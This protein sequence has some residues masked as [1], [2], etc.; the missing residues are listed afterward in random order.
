MREGE[1]EYSRDEGDR[2]CGA[3]DLPAWPRRTLNSG[4]WRSGNG[5][6]RIPCRAQASSEW[7]MLCPLSPDGVGLSWGAAIAR[8]ADRSC[9]S[10]PRQR[11]G[12]NELPEIGLS[13]EPISRRP[14]CQCDAPC[15]QGSRTPTGD[16][17]LSKLDTS[18]W[19]GGAKSA[20][21]S[22]AEQ[23]LPGHRRLLF[24][25]CGARVG[26]AAIDKFCSGPRQSRP[27]A[28]WFVESLSMAL[29]C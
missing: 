2:C 11:Q 12:G 8:R 26:R 7:C 24:R 23:S 27:R 13:P 25:D 21:C 29:S 20:A 18:M 28:R 1:T 5:R 10:Q 14:S 22:R 19:P 6:H 9:S 17:A 3:E 4:C 15:P 16:A